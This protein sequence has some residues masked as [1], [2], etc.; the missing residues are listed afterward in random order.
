[1]TEFKIK[2]IEGLDNPEIKVKNN[3]RFPS[4]NNLPKQ[5]FYVV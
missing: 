2:K 4:P 1:M 5:F 3:Y